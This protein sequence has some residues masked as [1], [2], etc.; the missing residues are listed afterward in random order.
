ML[1]NDFLTNAAGGAVSPKVL[2]VASGTTAGGV[3]MA[4]LGDYMFSLDT[5]AF[6]TLQR[7]T[8]FRWPL[9][10]RIGRAPA[11]QFTGLGEDKIELQGAIYPHFR[12]GLGQVGLM[13]ESAARGDPLPLIYGFD[14]VGQYCGLWCIENIQESRSVFIR[15]GSP[16]KIEFSLSL[17]YYGEDNGAQAAY[18]P[19]SAASAFPADTATAVPTLLGSSGDGLLSNASTVANL[20][21][22]DADSSVSDIN[23]VAAALAAVATGAS[24]VAAH[25]LTAIQGAVSGLTPGAISLIPS[26]AITAVNELSNSA[27]AIQSA[28]RYVSASIP[29][30][31][32]SPTGI[33]STSQSFDSE[34]Q[35]I[36]RD[37]I[38]HGGTVRSAALLLG[39]LEPAPEVSF[40]DRIT[41]A[42]SLS[43]V[44]LASDHLVFACS[45]AQRQAAV[46][47][48][49]IRV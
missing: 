9:Q 43:N 18:V 39:Y 36:L 23:R 11:A 12:G 7:Q 10:N 35:G 48:E 49:G 46:I 25:A 40:F 8:A 38:V 45:E 14:Q 37:T 41:A 30:F 4:K 17:T 1:K 24:S 47:T 27:Q 20:P 3:Y 21:E 22:I 13:R 29:V 19:L 31:E 42:S 34:M 2:N 33:Q 5:S 28:Q 6:Q 16:L 26:D 15:N 44:T 32:D